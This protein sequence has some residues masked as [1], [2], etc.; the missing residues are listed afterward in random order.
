[1]NYPLPELY[2]TL[3]SAPE[4]PVNVSVAIVEFSTINVTWAPPARPNGNII[5]YTVTY[6]R[7]GQEQDRKVSFAEDIYDCDLNTDVLKL[8]FV[9]NISCYA[10]KNIFGN[11]T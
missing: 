3:L 4:A 5:I 2:C 11:I 1:M 10:I 9:K 6:W 8:A 7:V